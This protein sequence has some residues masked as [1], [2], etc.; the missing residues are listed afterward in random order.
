MWWLYVADRR[1]KAM[2]CLPTKVSGLRMKYTVSI[3]QTQLIESTEWKSAVF[4][5]M[6]FV[7]F[8]RP[9]CSLQL[10][11]RQDSIDTVLS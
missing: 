10:R 7:I 5:I 9:I 1:R 11:I 8:A 6:Y 2:V 3:S 4:I